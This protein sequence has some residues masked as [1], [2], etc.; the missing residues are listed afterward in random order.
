MLRL[1][2]D[3]FFGDL[4]LRKT[5]DGITLSHRVAS[6]AP[7]EVEKHTH[8]DAHFVLVT[9]GDY[10]STARGE[11]LDRALIYNPPETTHRDHFR[12]GSGSFFTISISD[13]WLARFTVA[14]P[15][16]TATHATSRRAYGLTIALLME[17]ARWDCSSRLKAESMCIELLT[18][19][20]GR[21][22]AAPGHGQPKWL[23]I[24][25][26]RVLDCPGD[27][28]NITQIA[29]SVGVHPVH[30]TRAFR[31]YLGCTPGDLRRARRLELAAAAL[32]KSPRSLA[33]IALESGFRDQSQFT[34]AFGRLYGV[35]P[36][37]YRRTAR[38]F[39]RSPRDVAF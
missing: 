10:V 11:A 26:E 30:L 3:V 9:S 4:R 36:G 14:A 6:S 25:C 7:N 23:A 18:E 35:P 5:L 15:P 19:V 20:S 17:C 38:S 24:A 2:H 21:H 12:A 27:S 16:S 22:V 29:R 8:A 39:L 37:A 33:E 1:A 32:M 28:T 13:E 34:K 31:T